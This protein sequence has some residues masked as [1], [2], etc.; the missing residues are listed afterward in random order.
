MFKTYFV[1]LA[2]GL[3]RVMISRDYVI[4]YSYLCVQEIV[5][6][7]QYTTNYTVKT[8]LHSNSICLS[9]CLKLGS[10]YAAQLRDVAKCVMPRWVCREFRL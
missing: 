3:A 7:F 2:L 4:M 6:E 5:T 9:T 1:C 10:Q 8:L